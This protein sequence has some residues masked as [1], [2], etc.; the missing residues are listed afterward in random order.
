MSTGDEP[1]ARTERQRGE[2]VE[3]RG[4]ERIATRSDGAGGERASAPVVE[5]RTEHLGLATAGRPVDPRPMPRDFSISLEAKR[6]ADRPL[7]HPVRGDRLQP[8]RGFEDTFTDI[9]DYIL[10]VT[11]RIW[12]EKGIGYLYEHYRHNTTV[13]GDHGVVYG[14]DQV[15]VDTAQYISAFPDVRLYADEIVWC[16]D[17]DVGFYTSHRTIIV[18]HNT[19]Y[20]RWGPPTGRKV[21]VCCIANCKSLENQIVEEF[22]IYNTGSL[23]RQLGFDLRQQAREMAG[24]DRL[25]PLDAAR[26]GEAERLLGQGSPLPLPPAPD[27]F[28]IED[29]VRRSHHYIWNWRLLDRVDEAYAP[30]VRVHGPTDRELYGRGDYKAYV[31]SLLAAFPDLVHQIDD[32]YWM[33]NDRDGYLT[34]VRWSIV[35]THRGPGFYG[36]PTG[37]RVVMWGITQ[38]RILGGRIV[39]EWTAA[40]EFDLL[41]QIYREEAAPEA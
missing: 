7:V 24:G 16:G 35:G 39:E 8:M 1:H 34:A 17:E 23:L 6:A 9:V 13:V 14:R 41:Q 30:Q 4:G 2:P 36:E 11:H 37:R 3:E 28:D 38:Q 27:D 33:G 26:A 21:V 10:R 15:I 20:S 40:N 18:G 12:D 22:V 25:D 29:F 31:L 32:L 5:M 19:G